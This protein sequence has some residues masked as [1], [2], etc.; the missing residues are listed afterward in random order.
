MCNAWIYKIYTEF[1]ANISILMNSDKE[2]LQNQRVRIHLGTQEVMARIFILEDS[3][4]N[5]KD[6]V[7]IIKFEKDII[8][9]FQDRY[10]IRSYSPITTIGGG[11]ILDTNIYGKWSKNKKYSNELYKYSDTINTLIYKI[12]ERDRMSPYTLNSLSYKLG[13]SHKLIFEYL[14]NEDCIYFGKK[15]NPWV[16]TNGQI[17]FIFKKILIFVESFHEKNKFSKGVNKEEINNILNIDT[18][19]LDDILL[20]LIENKKLKKEK[21]KYFANDFKIKLDKTD[22]KLRKDLIFY[23]TRSGF[24]TPS[25]NELAGYFK[26]DEKHISKIV[27]IER[28]N[29]NLIIIDGTYIFTNE[30]YI[31]LIE[32]IAKHFKN[33]DTL[34][35]KEFKEISQTTRKYAVPLL[36]YL[37]KKNITYREE[38]YRKLA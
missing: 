30:N 15:D 7:A 25:I 27:T 18:N 24:N 16:L 19:L 13:L 6:L 28:N 22:E 23:L 11:I 37:D 29:N 38:N 3:S 33:Y 35:I 1:G 26:K 21:E 32:K 2:I 9:S 8:A 10:I 17:D 20:S 31:K 14:K 4:L 36:E 34:S 5:K 12:I